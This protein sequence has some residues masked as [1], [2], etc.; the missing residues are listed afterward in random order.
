MN[1][2]FEPSRFASAVETMIQMLST[3]GPSQTIEAFDKNRLL[4]RIRFL[5]D[6]LHE[7]ADEIDPVHQPSAIMHLFSPATIGRLIGRELSGTEPRPLEFVEP[8][9]GT[10]VY[11]L[12]YSGT[13][14]AY[15]P[16]SKTKCPIYV[17]TADPKLSNAKTPREQGQGLF[18]RL[19]KHRKNI[20]NAGDSLRITD[21]Q[22][23]YLVTETGWQATAEEFLIGL[24]RPVWNK[25]SKVCSGF[26]KH[27]DLA[28][29][30]LSKW[31]ILHAGRKWAERQSSLRG[32]TRESVAADIDAYFVKVFESDP[33]HWR[34]LLNPDWI[35]ERL[36]R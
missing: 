4:K 11:A 13:F 25:E 36:R 9:Y 12:Y 26:G 35:K 31:D 7:I 34:Q 15:R 20:Q 17:G 5:G 22:Y 3:S 14:L 24:Y 30:E 33:Q 23:R 19:A 10:G 21:F 6:R 29:K 18:S 28:R 32:G 8:F 27:G 2:Q 1:N 16:I